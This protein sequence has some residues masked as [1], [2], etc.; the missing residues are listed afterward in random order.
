MKGMIPFAL[1][2]I[3]VLAGG[4]RSLDQT[5][6]YVSPSGDDTASGTEMAPL[7][8]LSGAR[9]RV[10]ALKR[11]APGGRLEGAVSVVFADGVY[12]IERTVEFSAEDSGSPD[13]PIVYRAA[14]RGKVTFSGGIAPSW[15]RPAADDPYLAIV[16]EDVRNRV[17]VTDLPEGLELPGFGGGRVFTNDCPVIPYA[18]GKP[19]PVAAWPDAATDWRDQ[20]VEFAKILPDDAE[21][22]A[23]NRADG[24]TVAFRTDSK[25]LAVWAKEPDL[26]TYGMWQVEW[27]DSHAPVRAVDPS[28]G[29]V[30]I[31]RKSICYPPGK[32]GWFRVINAFSEMDRPGEWAVDRKGR[33]LYL[34][35]RKNLGTVWLSWTGTI[36]KAT[37][38]SDV[39]FDGIR[40]EHARGDVLS[41][42]RCRSVTVQGCT[43]TA[44]GGWGIVFS[45]GSDNVAEGNDLNHLGEGGI[46][47]SGGNRPTLRPGRAAAVNNH[48]HHYGERVWAYRPAVSLGMGSDSPLRAACIGNRV[49]HNLIHHARHMGIGF[50]GNDNRIAYNVIH[51]VCAWTYDAGAIYGY[52]EDDWA[53]M[54]GTVIEHNLVYMTGKQPYTS[55]TD[56]IYLDGITSGVTVRGN[57][58]IRAS[59]GIFQNGGQANVYEGNVVA[60][61]KT[62]FQR[63]DLGGKIVHTATNS[64]AWRHLQDSR[65]ILTAEPWSVRYP[66]LARQAVME[67]A[68]FA[69]HS[70]FTVV[71]D[72]VFAASGVPVHDNLAAIA[73]YSTVS[74]NLDMTG[75]P[76]FVDFKGLDFGFRSGSAGARMT[77]GTHFTQMGLFT[78]PLRASPAVKF[79]EDVTPAPPLSLP[80]SEAGVKIDVTMDGRTFPADVSLAKDL[81]NCE[82]AGAW[83]TERNRICANLGNPPRD[84]S[85]KTYSFAF[86]PLVS[87]TYTLNL[88][89]EH[90]EKTRIDD[91]RVTG[92]RLANGGFE[93]DGHW[94]DPSPMSGA[95]RRSDISRPYGIVASTPCNPAAQGHR[96]AVV[97]HDLV[98]KGAVELT[99]GE[100]VTVTFQAAAWM[101]ERSER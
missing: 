88:M 4:F 24:Q 57:I 71:R 50:L 45:G 53:D 26:W 40:F 78:S 52:T 48:I 75:D 16:P 22:A 94:S 31:S 73:A 46:V 37:D 1:S 47:L 43:L 64:V 9:D 54:R 61:C 89:G 95:E 23:R 10:R 56:G 80:M 100:R 76:G 85:W 21:L 96:Q 65:R 83:C 39:S 91:L 14:H 63:N 28:A 60:C 19:L 17:A 74:N 18:H 38:V 58:V 35:Y 15:R 92:A 44:C 49:E 101:K 51:D 30:T 77:G 36:V 27:D 99:A 5:V 86:T 68:A 32:R 66:D 29:T 70:L 13:A 97:S 82:M 34:L 59:H 2:L 33:R 69:Q 79:G 87:G 12:P 42:S 81:V 11:K 67:D 72:N 62:P 93:Q 25:N 41:F 8:T 7:K 84:G 55:A 98:M 6:L 3:A 90:G 20:G